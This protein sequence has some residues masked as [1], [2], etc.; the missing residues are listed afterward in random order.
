MFPILVPVIVK[1]GKGAALPLLS[2]EINDTTT[3]SIA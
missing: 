3:H 1:S 2:D